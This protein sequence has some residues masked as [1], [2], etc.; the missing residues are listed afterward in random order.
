VKPLVFFHG[1][2]GRPA[3]VREVREHFGAR[4]DVLAPSLPGHGPDG[5][6]TATGAWDD[7]VAMLTSLVTPGAVLVGYSLGARLA[8]GVA[9]RRTD[10][11]GLVLA[12]GHPGLRGDEERAARRALDESRAREL[13]TDGLAVFAEAWGQEPIVQLRAASVEAKAARAV[14]RQEHVA[15]GIAWSLRALGLGAMPFLGDVVARRPYPVRLV[16]GELDSK[17]TALAAELAAASPALSHHVAPLAGHDVFLDAPAY[18][19]SVL[20]AACA[21]SPSSS[22]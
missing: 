5:D 17:F 1:F 16:T 22:S 19:A 10:L 18:V 11:G 2:L 21:L 13:E 3:H 9:A 8:L 4:V 20:R 12:S 6:C 7:A 15:S 14:Q